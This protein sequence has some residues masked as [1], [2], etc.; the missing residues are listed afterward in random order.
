M[1]NFFFTSNNV[2]GPSTRA[3]MGGTG[4]AVTFIGADISVISTTATVV[5]GSGAGQ[6]V[7]VLGTLMSVTSGAA[8]LTGQDGLVLVHEGAVVQGAAH[9]PSAALDLS[10]TGMR[11]E[12]YGTMIGADGL[13]L[14][15][16]GTAVISGFLSG[17]GSASGRAIVLEMTG[18]AGAVLEIAGQIRGLSSAIAVEG[19]GTGVVDLFNT[20][21]IAGDVILGAGD[22]VI[23]NAAMIDGDLLLGD[24]KNLYRSFG[25]GLVTGEIHGGTGNDRIHGSASDEHVELGDGRDFARLGAGDDYAE[26]GVGNDTLFGMQG[27]DTLLGER[28]DDRLYGWAGDDTLL[29]GSKND[30]LYGGRGDDLLDGGWDDDLLNGGRGDDELTGGAGAD[31]FVFGR[32]VGLDIVTDFELG[33]DR[34]DLSHFGLADLADLDA[35]GGLIA[36]Q[37]SARIDMG[38]LGGSGSVLLENVS[39]GALGDGDFLF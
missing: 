1:S 23:R 7:T 31:T 13:A 8:A 25:D 5:A 12:I 37:G 3:N 33:T 32:N 2:L 29:G 21:T 18:T 38:A 6:S 27:D 4:N 35:K 39:A 22:D 24:G 30:E 15:E 17:V 14:G 9:A 19:A 16:G 20:G 28:G 11:A 36:Q 10:G 34:I 26:G